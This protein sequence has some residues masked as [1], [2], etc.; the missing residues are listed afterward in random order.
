MTISSEIHPS[1]VRSSQIRHAGLVALRVGGQWRGA[2][3]EG[4]S[5]SGKSDLALRAIDDGFRLVSD[6]RTVVFA[7]QGRLFGRAPGPLSGLIESRGVGV[8]R[9]AA[10]PFAEI[11]FVAR[12]VD[13]P[14]AVERMP[15]PELQ[16]LLGL[17]APVLRLWPFELSAP[18]KLRRALEALGGGEQEAYQASLAPPRRRLGA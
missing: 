7:S 11:L 8:Q 4:P 13:Q 3:I 6:D 9:E 17:A 14:G 2:L 12:C 18:A 1:E 5:G 10:L 16:P 15:D